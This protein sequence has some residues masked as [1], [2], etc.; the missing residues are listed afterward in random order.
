MFLIITAIAAIITTIIWY[1][2][3]PNDKYRLGT[4]CLMFW[5]ATLMW[6]PDHII[7]YLTEGGAFFEINLDA[8]LLGISVVIIG[9]IAWIILLLIKDPKHV[10]FSTNS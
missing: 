8:T 2:K 6:I 5:G 7:A 4:L 3:S 10:L 1:A 9:L